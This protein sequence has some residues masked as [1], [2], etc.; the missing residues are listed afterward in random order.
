MKKFFILMILLLPLY[1][2]AQISIG[3]SP[4]AKQ[5]HLKSA[6]G[7]PAYNLKSIDRVK[8]TEEDEEFPTP[9]RYSVFEN[10]Q[11]NIYEGRKTQISVVGGTLW[12]Y[13]VKA[14]GAGS[15]QIIFSKFVVPDKAALYIYDREYKNVAGAFTRENMQQDS[16][17]VIADFFSDA[18]IIEYFEPNN[19]EFKG[20]VMIGKI[21][22]AYRNLLALSSEDADGY[23]GVNCP[24][25]NEWQ[26][27]KHAVCFITFESGG[28]GYM[29]SGALINNVKNDRTPYFLTANHCIS[30][31]ASATTLVSYF[32]FEMQGCP[33]L[34]NYGYKTMTGSTLMTTFAGSDYTLL[35]LASTPPLTFKPYYAGWDATGDIV[36]SSAGIHHPEGTPKKISLDFDPIVSFDDVI[37]W[38]GGSETIANTH[39]QVNFDAGRTAGGSS[40]SPLFSSEKKI[41]GQLHG[42]DDVSNFYG[43]LSY[44]FT[45]KQSSYLPLKDYLDPDNT[46]AMKCDGYYPPG[47]APEVHFAADFDAVCVSAPVTLTDYSAFS[48]T[49]REWTFNPSAVTY[50]NGTDKNSAQPVVSFNNGGSYDITL[51]V[52]NSAGTSARTLYGLITAGNAIDAGITTVGLVDSCVNDFDSIMLQGTGGTSFEW[53]IL[54]DTGNYFFFTVLDEKTISVKMNPDASVDKNVVMHVKTTGTHGT[55]TGTA[56]ADYTLIKQINDEVQ[57]AMPVVKGVNGPFSNCCSGIEE[58]EPIPPYTSC[59]GQ[60]SWCDEYGNG[61]NIVE[62]SVWFTVTGPETELLTVKAEGFDAEL[63]LY[64]A[65]TYQD[66]LSGNYE[67][68]AANDDFT[69][70]DP[71]PEISKVPVT[72]GKKYWVQVDGSGGGTQSTFT[73]VVFDNNPTRVDETSRDLDL[74]IYPQPA[75][76]FLN[77]KCPALASGI[78][79]ISIYTIQGTV[80]YESSD[81][82]AASGLLTIP[83]HDLVTGL[84]F[85]TL[86]GSDYAVTAR[87]MKE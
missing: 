29:C 87:F 4:Y 55:C 50:L 41:I 10:V 32:N 24:E 25:G 43:K 5:L 79:T 51:S 80:V 3:G 27:E 28:N 82:Y 64:D 75:A 72:A 69:D 66:L 57:Y 54:N 12:Q 76:D 1:T 11:I 62:H 39:W 78:N 58:G 16:T 47:I 40:G 31:K 6:T 42:G 71:H 81:I 52:T 46:G 67:L 74:I 21:G 26:N 53:E 22:Q 36:P 7:I 45:R 14:P 34:P 77:I 63:A 70:T 9:Q 20:E 18:L 49:S 59:T 30:S 35:K 2:Y 68:V 48:P 15:V 44:S 84:Y 37:S 83:V 85:V 23:I 86:T 33:G 38:E 65:D 56:E 60:K 17:F 61:E 13:E 8:L 19:S 73:L